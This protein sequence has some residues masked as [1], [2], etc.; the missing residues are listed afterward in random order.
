M[1]TLCLTLGLLLLN[2]CCSKALQFTMTPGYCCFSFLNRSLPPARVTSITE[3]HRS[4]PQQAFIVQTIK[5]KQI[6]YRQTFPWAIHVYNL[7]HN[8]EGSG[9]QH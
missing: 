8:T 4:C 6:C 1:K 2:V 9:Q 3:T 7:L 5:G